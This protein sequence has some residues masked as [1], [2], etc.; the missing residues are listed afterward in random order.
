MKGPNIYGRRRYPWEV[1]MQKD[2][3]RVTYGKHFFCTTESFIQALWK[4]SKSHGYRFS[5]RRPDNESIIITVKERGL[6][7]VHRLS[8]RK[9][10]GVEKKPVKT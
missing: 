2:R 4:W 9:G 1:W 8:H 10:K 7:P 6:T 5:I 3:F